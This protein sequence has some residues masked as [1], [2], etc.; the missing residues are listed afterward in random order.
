MGN[1]V[2]KTINDIHL[3]FEDLYYTDLSA[4]KKGIM[5]AFDPRVKLISALIL[6]V[7]ANLCKNFYGLG[8]FFLYTLVLAALSR[9]N[10]MKYILRVSTVSILFGGI[11]LIPSLF[12]VVSGGRPF[13]HL[14]KWLYI[15]DEGVIR[16][17]FFMMRSFISL[18]FIYLI[19]VTTR[20]LDLMK[21]LRSVG[22]PDV[23]ASVLE[24]TNRYIFLFLELA[25]NMFLARKSRSIKNIDGKEGRRFVASSIGYLLI[26]SGDLSNDVYDAMVARGYHGEIKTISHFKLKKWD[27]LWLVFNAVFVAIAAVEGGIF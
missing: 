25:S 2:E 13:L 12:N 22:I 21:A 16:A 8:M 1:F 18:S 24:M 11:V 17:I 4:S 20:W 27:Y 6:V 3:I 7:F 26:R 15:T 10:Y 23:F 14:G 19:T 5:Q 9:I